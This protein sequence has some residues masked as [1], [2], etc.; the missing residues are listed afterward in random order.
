MLFL[1]PVF[2]DFPTVRK[3]IE[4]KENISSNEYDYCKKNIQYRAEVIFRLATDSI[5]VT[6]MKRRLSFFDKL[7]AFGI[8]QKIFFTALFTGCFPGFCKSETEK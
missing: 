4:F 3:F 1:I 5:S 6:V 8:K 7:S 2:Y